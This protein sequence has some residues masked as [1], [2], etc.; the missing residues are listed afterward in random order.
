M[1]Q[2]KKNRILADL[3]LIGV[4]FVWGSGFVSSK[5]AIAYMSPMMLM[6][7]RFTIAS[8][9]SAFIFKKNL[10][11][12]S[13]ETLKAGFIIGLFLFSAFTA[14]MVGLQYV[15]A[16]KQAFLTAT[17]VI[18]VP[19]VYWA[20]KK[21][22][23]DKY[24]FIAA[25]IMF[26]GLVLLTLDF[27]SGFSFSPGDALTLFCAFLFACH[28][29]SIGIFAGKHDPIA[30]T[31]IQLSVAA[32]LSLVYVIFSGDILN[33]TFSQTG[34]LNAAYLGVFCTFLAFL[35][36]TMAQ[37][38]TTAT[39]T[40]IILSLESVFGSFLS[41]LIL[42][43]H[44]TFLMFI[45]CLVIFIGILTAETKWAF[46]RKKNPPLIEIEESNS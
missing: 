29:V 13:K 25:F 34:L 26:L 18:M 10:K 7:L 36:Q 3:V 42:N 22:K 1:E 15:E 41:I 44:F 17:N 6:A 8:L 28:I 14:Q 23:P 32:I 16:G 24:N 37:K 4:A 2:S 45:G 35:G 19:F 21:K 20:V 12:I 9:L 40:A 5:T 30:L 11:S 43:E 46:L 33:F 27:T 39:H 31:V 38:Y